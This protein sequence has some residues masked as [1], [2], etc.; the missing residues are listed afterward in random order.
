LIVA[1]LAL[2]VIAFVFALIAFGFSLYAIIS[3]KSLEKS[4]HTMVESMT[5]I[6]DALQSQRDFER[7]M[8]SSEDAYINLKYEGDE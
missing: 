3:A 4:T 6:S 7:A 2:S 1:A 8:A 5:P